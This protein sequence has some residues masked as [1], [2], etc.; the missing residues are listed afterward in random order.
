V[1]SHRQRYRQH[2]QVRPFV[3]AHGRTRTRTRH[4]LL[5]NTLVSAQYDPV[6]AAELTPQERAVYEYAATAEG[7]SVAEVSAHTRMSLG[8]VR[9][10]LGDLAGRG[11]I[12]IHA[13]SAG[14]SGLEPSPVDYETLERLLRGLEQL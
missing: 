7:M 10:I 1:A 13:A 12:T 2:P 5:V 6:L 8:L 9:V 14:S 4:P 3:L 11:A